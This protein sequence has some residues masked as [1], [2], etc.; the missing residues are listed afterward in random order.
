MKKHKIRYTVPLIEIRVDWDDRK[1]ELS[2]K[3]ISEAVG[4]LIKEEGASVFIIRSTEWAKLPRDFVEELR[5]LIE[6]E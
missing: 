5:I 6:Y 4:N 3:L 2:T 1:K